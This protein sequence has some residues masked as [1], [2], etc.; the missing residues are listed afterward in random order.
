M[1]QDVYNLEKVGSNELAG[2]EINVEGEDVEREGSKRRT[3]KMELR[4]RQARTRTHGDI[5]I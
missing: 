2:R 1:C 4:G 3:E 5:N